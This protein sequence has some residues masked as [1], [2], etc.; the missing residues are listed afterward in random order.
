MIIKQLSD[1]DALTEEEAKAVAKEF[2]YYFTE[3]SKQWG[4]MDITKLQCKYI[5]TDPTC[6]KN[7]C[8]K[9]VAV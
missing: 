7:A 6:I 2:I 3:L 9:S 5:G 8:I 4:K 1:I